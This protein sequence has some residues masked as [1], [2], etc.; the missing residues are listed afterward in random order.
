MNEQL[1]VVITAEINKLKTELGKGQKLLAGF[2][3]AGVKAGKTLSSSF[4]AVGSAIGKAVKI[5]SVAITALATAMV[6]VAEKTRDYRKQQ[7]QLAASFRSAGSNAKQ[8]K[9]TYSELY[10]VLGDTGNATEAASQLAK[11]T[12]DTEN[13]A[14]WT[15]ICKGVYATFGNNIPIQSLTEAVNETAKTGEVTGALADALKRAG[16]DQDEFADQ[17]FWANSEAEREELIRRTLNG[18]YGEAADIYDETA[19]S[20][21]NA[22]DA[23]LKLTDTLA[24][25]GEAVE[26]LISIFKDQFANAL[27]DLIPHFTLVTEGVLDIVKGIEGG[28][29][30]VTEGITG[31]ID[32]IIDTI[33][34]A[35]PTVLNI[36][37]DLIFALFEGISSKLPDIIS[38]ITDFSVQFIN[39]CRE[40]I[41][42]VL[43]D[44]L[45]ATPDLINSVFIIFESILEALG[46]M[47]PEILENIVAIIPKIIE[48]LMNNIPTFLQAAITFLMAIVDAIPVVITELVKALPQIVYSIVSALLDSLP[49]LIQGVVDLV[50]GIVANL[51]QIIVAIIEAIPQI[52]Q[53]IMWAIIDCLPQIIEALISLTLGI[54]Q[55]LPKILVSLVDALI[56]FFMD[57]VDNIINTFVSLPENVGRV[58]GSAVESIKTAFNGISSYFTDIWNNIKL[59]FTNP[60]EFFKTKFSGAY[61]SAVNAFS[62]ARRGFANVWTNM[63]SGFGNVS[64]WFRTTFSRAWQSVKDVFSSGGKVFDGIK[65]GILDGLKSVINK[66]IVGINKVIKVPFDGINSAL[67]K[68]KGI[69]IFGH[70]P[71]DWM[72]TISVPQIPEL[73]KGGVLKKGQVGF[74]EGDGD[75]AVV[76]LEQ[77][78]E[79]IDKVANKLADVLGG[80]NRDIVLQVDGKTFARASINSINQLTRQTGKLALVVQ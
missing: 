38:V 67:Q 49:I 8:A 61:N 62:N 76:P 3:E 10:R 54:V 13:L 68:I 15:R 72:P 29:E 37:A 65:E 5:A 32:S 1:K 77:N 56:E 47:L 64:E 35:A 69:D 31:L 71:F 60:A 17:L 51:P 18:I 79:W 36:G 50:F 27:T 46:S 70:K 73:A 6:S 26:P 25:L 52:V 53:Q 57:L 33:T 21:L 55:N 59:I 45:S 66:L 42:T 24:A 16:Y 41:P 4:K 19:E 48:N 2:K 78:T 58:F 20:V 34:T 75:E 23:H 39:K 14:E 30:K 9:Q 80:S 7:A 40:I 63:K 44:I 22:N 11:L 43:K 74:L 28:R 12:T